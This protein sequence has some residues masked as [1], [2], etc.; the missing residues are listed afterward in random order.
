MFL[1]GAAVRQGML[2]MQGRY[3]PMADADGACDIR[4]LRKLTDAMKLIERNGMGI[5]IGSLAHVDDSVKV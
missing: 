1:L 4:D 2:S 3:G 5:S